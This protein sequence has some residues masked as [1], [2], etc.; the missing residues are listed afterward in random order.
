MELLAKLRAKPQSLYQAHQIAWDI[1]RRNN[2]DDRFVFRVVDDLM[3]VRSVSF[4]IGRKPIVPEAGKKYRLDILFDPVTTDGK[5]LKRISV[6]EKAIE[7][8]RQS[9]EKRGFEVEKIDGAYCDPIPL[10]KPGLQEVYMLPF[11]ATGDVFVKDGKL[12]EEAFWHG[13]GKSKRFGF[14]M[15]E[16]EAL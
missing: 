7:K 1:I 16:L 12:A 4:E 15:I 5:R 8:I 6:R 2:G 3:K 13:V 14:G 11:L 9:L 10:G